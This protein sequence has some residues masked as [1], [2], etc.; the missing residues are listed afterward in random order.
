MAT[1]LTGP[2]KDESIAPADPRPNHPYGSR[3]ARRAAQN[4]GEVFYPESDG[5]PIADNMAQAR[6]MTF[7][8][9]NL[10]LLYKDDPD[11]L[12]AMDLLWYPVKD[13]VDVVAAPDVMVIFGRPKY[14]RGSYKTW[15]EGGVAPQVVFEIMSDSN[16]VG[17]MLK[18]SG[19]YQQHG[20][21][22]FYLYDPDTGAF[23]VVLF[24]D[25]GMN[26]VSVE[27]EWTSP[28]LGVRFAPQARAD[29]EVY[30]PDGSPFQSFKE[31]Q[32]LLVYRTRERDRER[33]RANNE[34]LRADAE[35]GRADTERL[36]AEAE[37]KRADAETQARMAAEAEIARLRALVA[38]SESGS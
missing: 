29:M 18:K 11:V 32:E 27:T 26:V 25:S 13:K 15:A 8:S 9:T 31:S 6:W 4:S 10:G 36:R 3:A 17:E 12:V 30:Y 33:E 5:K 14:D 35:R 2:T 34:R 22:E 21:K 23:E 20:V 16:T 37:T 7:L 24:A 38:Q 1:L 28:L 19:F